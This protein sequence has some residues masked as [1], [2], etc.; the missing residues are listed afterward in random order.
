M[1]A[2]ALLAGVIEQSLRNV[3]PNGVAAVEPDRVDGL[4]F[5]DALAAATG[6][7]QHVPLDLHKLSLPHLGDIGL[8]AR[9]LE[10]RMP[11]RFGEGRIG[12]AGLRT[13]SEAS[14]SICLGFGMG[15]LAGRSVILELEHK[16]NECRVPPG[17]VLGKMI[18]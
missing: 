2:G 18:L 4:D 13:T 9:I 15:Q 16:E 1:P 6:D 14:F 10:H 7:P 5:H 11:V 12:A 3:L 17:L 8:G